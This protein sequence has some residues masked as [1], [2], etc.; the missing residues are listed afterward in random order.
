MRGLLSSSH[1]QKYNMTSGGVII[2]H[3]P[4][5][6]RGSIINLQPR[7]KTQKGRRPRAISF[8]DFYGSLG[9]FFI[10]PTLIILLFFIFI[11]PIPK[12]NKRDEK[13]FWHQRVTT[14]LADCVSYSFSYFYLFLWQ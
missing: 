9:A 6:E 3:Q 12:G 2:L 14:K 1:P 5:V 7:N 10:W 4:I 13:F 11:P 8:F